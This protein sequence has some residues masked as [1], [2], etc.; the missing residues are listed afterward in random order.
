MSNPTLK[1]AFCVSLAGHLSLFLVFTFS[2]GRHVAP[3][4]MPGVSF[5]GDILRAGDLTPH[6]A[7]A[8]PGRVNGVTSGERQDAFV[9][10]S[11]VAPPSFKDYYHKPASLV[12]ADPLKSHAPLEPQGLVPPARRASVVMLHPALPSHFLLYFK[13]RQQAH[14]ELLYSVARQPLAHGVTI[15]R[16]ISSGNLEVDLLCMRAMTRYFF[17]QQSHLEPAHW[18]TIKIDLSPKSDGGI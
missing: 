9:Q 13:D 16:K 2:F 10:K 14:L 8:D 5:L 15:K 11:T 17:I 3:L 6:G 1:N 7:G 12:V 18:Q 4:S